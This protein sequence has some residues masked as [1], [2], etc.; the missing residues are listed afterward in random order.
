M[1]KSEKK[2]FFIS[3][4]MK[5]INREDTTTKVLLITE[6]YSAMDEQQAVY[7]QNDSHTHLYT[8]RRTKNRMMVTIEYAV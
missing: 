5:P 3:Q 7:S 8:N 4:E 6:T 1:L 2:K